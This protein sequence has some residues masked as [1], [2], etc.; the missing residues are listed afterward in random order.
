MTSLLTCL[1]LLFVVQ[2]I[3]E[4]L[5]LRDVLDHMTREDL[6]DLKLKLV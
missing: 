1:D 3:A 4:Q 2:F 5:T 6:A